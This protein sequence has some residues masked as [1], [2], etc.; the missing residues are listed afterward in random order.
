MMENR[1]RS[2]EITWRPFRPVRLTTLAAFAGR[3]GSL[4]S[5]SSPLKRSYKIGGFFWKIFWPN[6]LREWIIKQS[7]FERSER[8]EY[9]FK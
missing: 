8:W 7:A 3:I 2:Q 5:V 1:E 9:D 4:E 6:H